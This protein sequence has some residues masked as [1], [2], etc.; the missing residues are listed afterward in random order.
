MGVHAEGAA[1]V[2]VEVAVGEAGDFAGA[3]VGRQAVQVG[4]AEAGG[5]GVAADAGGGRLGRARAAA[6]GEAGMQGAVRKVPARWAGE[7][8]MAR[9]RPWVRTLCRLFRT[10]P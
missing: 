3:A 4:G 6:Q 8:I 1:Q 2:A 9:I 10:T 5:E 7:V